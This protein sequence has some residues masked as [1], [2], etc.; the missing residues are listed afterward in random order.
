MKELTPEDG[1]AATAYVK[2]GGNGGRRGSGTG[3]SLVS[4]AL[5]RLADDAA[6]ADMDEAA[7]DA[8]VGEEEIDNM[9]VLGRPFIKAFVTRATAD[10]VPEDA[11]VEGEVGEVAWE[12][13]LAEDMD[14]VDAAVS[15]VGESKSETNEETRF[16]RARYCALRCW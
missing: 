9:G 7:F 1:V 8:E 13:V 15:K 4:T 10:A 5:K 12:S 3:P 6:D 2:A 14:A 16:A 11:N